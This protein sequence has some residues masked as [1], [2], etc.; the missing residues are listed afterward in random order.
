MLA[1]PVFFQVQKTPDAERPTSN[2]EIRSELDQ[3]F[4][5]SALG[6]RR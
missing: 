2:I 1:S 3:P 5:H 4:L 6:V